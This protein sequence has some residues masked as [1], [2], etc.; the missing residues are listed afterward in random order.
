MLGVADEVVGERDRGPQDGQQ[1]VL[2]GATVTQRG[3]QVTHAV[4]PVVVQPAQRLHQ[5]DQAQQRQVGVG[6]GAEGV[7]D[8]VAEEVVEGVD[9]PGQRR[10][11]QQLVGAGGVGEPQPGQLPRPAARRPRGGGHGVNLP[12]VPSCGDRA[13]RAAAGSG[14]SSNGVTWLR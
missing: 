8:A 5:P 6:D 1:P 2:A 12:R 3:D 10:V 9:Q 11:V 4:L 7:D 14:R 13:L